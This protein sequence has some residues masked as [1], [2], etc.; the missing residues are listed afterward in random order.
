MSNTVEKKLFELISITSDDLFDKFIQYAQY[1]TM[2]FREFQKFME[3]IKNENQQLESSNLWYQLEEYLFK[4]H[5]D[6]HWY[7]KCFKCGPCFRK[8]KKYRMDYLIKDQYLKFLE[9]EEYGQPVI[10]KQLTWG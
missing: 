7:T 1:Q 6:S 10:K 2:D 3:D 4:K 8:L 9:V 5:L